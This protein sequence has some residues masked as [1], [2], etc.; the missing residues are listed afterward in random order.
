[1]VLA[2]VVE[3]LVLVLLLLLLSWMVLV[4]F[5]G[6]FRLVLKRSCL[7]VSIFE[8]RIGAHS[9]GFCGHRDHVVFLAT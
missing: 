9:G 3:L 8:G 4:C 2:V 1:M 7:F 5:G 6:K